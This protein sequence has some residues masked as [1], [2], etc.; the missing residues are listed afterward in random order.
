VAEP[1]LSGGRRWPKQQQVTEEPPVTIRVSG[2]VGEQ[3]GPWESNQG[4]GFVEHEEAEQIQLAS[5]PECAG[6]S[7]EIA[8]ARRSLGRLGRCE[9][10][11]R[12]TRE[13]EIDERVRGWVGVGVRPTQPDQLGRDWMGH[14]WLGHWASPT[15]HWLYYYF[16]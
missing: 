2:V 15:D 11:Q 13:K 12:G 7:Q 10:K 4:E 1:T 9:R 14:C 3:L 16:F 5:A 6:G 8:A